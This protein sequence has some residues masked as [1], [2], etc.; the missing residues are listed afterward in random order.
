MDSQK[1]MNIFFVC[2]KSIKA[3]YPRR[4]NK[5]K[6]YANVIKPFINVYD[7]NNVGNKFD[8]LEDFKKEMALSCI[9]FEP[10]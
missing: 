7:K 9:I 1:R 2:I 4:G 3:G 10:K 8:S 6:R 5:E